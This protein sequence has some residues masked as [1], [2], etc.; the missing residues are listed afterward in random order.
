MAD[1]ATYVGT[2]TG[3]QWA[4]EE[5]S[6]DVEETV[7]GVDQHLGIVQAWTR[8]DLAEGDYLGAPRARGRPV[9]RLWYRRSREGWPGGSSWFHDLDK[10]TGHVQEN[11]DGPPLVVLVGPDVAVCEGPGDFLCG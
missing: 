3:I 11:P 6:W 9:S 4:D 2:L 7:L 10:C 8:R 5:G 1:P